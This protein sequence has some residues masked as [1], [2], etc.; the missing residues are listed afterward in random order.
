MEMCASIDRKR[1][2]ASQCREHSWLKPLEGQSERVKSID[3][4]EAVCEESSMATLLTL[5]RGVVYH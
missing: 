4:V 3:A 5:S 2:S 1:M